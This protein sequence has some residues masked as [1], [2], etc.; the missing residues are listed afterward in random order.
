MKLSEFKNAIQSGTPLSFTLEDGSIVPVHYHLTEIGRVSKN[1][2]DCGGR[3]RSEEKI[4]FQLWYE[5]DTDH[6]LTSEKLLKIIQIGEEKIGLPDLNIEVEYQNTTIGKY[7]LQLGEF[8]FI[9]ANSQTACL[10]LDSCGIPN[11][12]VKKQ[13]VSLASGACEPNSGCC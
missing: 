9:L 1:F 4:S 13:L 7:S 3:Q 10:A 12:K 8:G 11:A 2:I 5:Q 6:R